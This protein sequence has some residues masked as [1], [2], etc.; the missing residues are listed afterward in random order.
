MNSA[1]PSGKTGPAEVAAEPHR[2]QDSFSSKPPA[3]E[4]V[5]EL[6]LC[7]LWW[8]KLWLGHRLRQVAAE[9]LEPAAT[10]RETE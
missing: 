10:E 3:P 1:G 9:L 2:F 4:A 8:R 5:D 7:H 6:D